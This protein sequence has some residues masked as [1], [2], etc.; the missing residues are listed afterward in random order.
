MVKDLEEIWAQINNDWAVAALGK[1]V[2]ERNLVLE[3]KKRLGNLYTKFKGLNLKA[4]RLDVVQVM[5]FY[6]GGLL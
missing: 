3:L 1:D 6:T 5:E 2:K 4:S